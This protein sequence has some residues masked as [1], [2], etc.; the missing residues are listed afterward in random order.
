[1]KRTLLVKFVL[2]STLALS[3]CTAPALAQRGQ[4]NGGGSPPAFGGG[5]FPGMPSMKGMFRMMGQSRMVEPIQSNRLIL[6]NRND[7]R[8][9]LGLSAKQREDLDGQEEK[10]M[11]TMQSNIMS[12]VMARMSDLQT[13]RDLP[14]EEQ[15]SKLMDFVGEMRGTAE[16]AMKEAGKDYDKVLTAKQKKRLTEIDLQYRGPLAVLDPEVG[17]TLKLTDEQKPELDKILADYRKAQ[18]EQVKGL[19]GRFGG[20]GASGGG[21]QAA[22]PDPA[23]IQERVSEIQKEQ[24]KV[25]EDLGKKVL[26]LLTDQ[27]KL[28]WQKLQGRKF[29][30]RPNDD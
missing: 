2:A 1:M 24:D 23:S 13:L 30:F 10:T 21:G 7:V 15:Q 5:A 28:D 14:K 22:P 25:R 18:Q 9:E 8:G 17:E 3:V 11:Q 4:K 16:A 12:K 20:L 26:A 27:Q 6:I 29:V 19:M